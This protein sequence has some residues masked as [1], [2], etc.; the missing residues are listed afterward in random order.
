[1]RLLAGSLY[2]LRLQGHLGMRVSV[3]TLTPKLMH[4]LHN[5]AQN[6]DPA[7]AVADPASLAKCSLSLSCAR[8]CQPQVLGIKQQMASQFWG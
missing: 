5:F 8:I 3:T 7:I 1:M 2:C 6:V 4:T